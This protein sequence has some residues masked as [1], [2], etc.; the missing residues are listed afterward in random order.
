VQ[1]A[2]GKASSPSR[3]C[4]KVVAIRNVL[5]SLSYAVHQQT[6]SSVLYTTSC[7]HS[8]VLLRMGEINAW[9]MLS[10]LKL[11]IKLLLLLYLVGC[12]NYCINIYSNWSGEQ[13]CNLS[14]NTLYVLLFAT[15][16]S[17]KKFIHVY[18][19]IY[20]YIYKVSFFLKYYVHQLSH[21]SLIS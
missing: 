7:K 20:I 9:N 1:P 13:F 6:A 2:F 19:Y 17:Y 16:L 5:S 12:S 14:L 4:N 8:L 21:M 10:W 3:M 18:I 15:N 11:L